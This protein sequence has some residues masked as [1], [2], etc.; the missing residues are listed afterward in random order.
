MRLAPRNG[1]LRAEFT[2][3]NTTE[4]YFDYVLKK[5]IKS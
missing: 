3:G 2:Y 1:A 5:M 4:R